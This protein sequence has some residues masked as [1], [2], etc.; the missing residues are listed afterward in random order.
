MSRS[1]APDDDEDS[2]DPESAGDIPAI[3][4]RY[5]APALEK[6]L[7]IIELLSGETRPMS[8]ATIAERLRRSKSELFRMLQVL[9]FR[10]YIARDEEGEGYVAT[11]KLFRL[12]MVQP[13]QRLLT[14]IATPVM[15]RLAD[16]LEQSCHLVV[17]AD[18]EVVVILRV[19]AAGGL[20]FSVRVGYRRRLIEA[21]SGLILFA[22]QPEDAA[23]AWLRRLRETAGEPAIAAFL[24]KAAVIREQRFARIDSDFAAGITDLSTPLLNGDRA[25]AA[26]TI[27]YVHRKPPRHSV[28][29]ALDVLRKAAA[30]I[31]AELT[32]GGVT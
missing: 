27:P 18:D 19:E 24:A 6:G 11:N 23:A 2:R 7:E 14:E 10:G 30:T 26:L 3:G 17:P 9:E 8:F 1:E 28:E 22:F 25:V 15:R 16:T 4:L 13:R 5:R 12:G 29:E 20:G 21:T 32:Y 31:S